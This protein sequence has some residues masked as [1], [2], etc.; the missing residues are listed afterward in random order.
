MSTQLK[1]PLPDIHSSSTGKHSSI[2]AAKKQSLKFTTNGR[3]GSRGGPHDA[4]LG[5]DAV[6]QRFQTNKNN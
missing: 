4:G 1:Q 3:S 5:E 6:L 2:A